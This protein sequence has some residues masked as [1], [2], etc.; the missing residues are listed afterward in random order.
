[1]QWL[2]KEVVTTDALP[3]DQFMCFLEPDEFSI[4]E[5]C[6]EKNRIYSGEYS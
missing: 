5:Q 1:M 6:V 4:S 3:A 2:F